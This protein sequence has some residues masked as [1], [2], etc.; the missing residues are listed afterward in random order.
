[1]GVYCVYWSGKLIASVD[2]PETHLHDIVNVDGGRYRVYARTLT[3]G[4]KVVRLDVA[5]VT[6]EELRA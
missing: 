3:P 5:L 1:M 4:S 2:L 6:E